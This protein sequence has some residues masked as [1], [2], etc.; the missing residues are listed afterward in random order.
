MI[1]PPV[2]LRTPTTRLPGKR[3]A[4]LFPR[5]R[6]VRAARFYPNPKTGRSAGFPQAAAG[7]RSRANKRAT[8]TSWINKAKIE[9]KADLFLMGQLWGRTQDLGQ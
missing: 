5:D 1:N 6:T 4:F 3:K 2:R 9:G 8:E 7:I